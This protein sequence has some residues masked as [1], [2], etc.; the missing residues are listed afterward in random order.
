VKSINIWTH[1]LAGAFFL[2]QGWTE[3]D[4]MSQVLPPMGRCRPLLVVLIQ[5]SES[6]QESQKIVL[7]YSISM[8]ISFLGSAIF[9]WFNPCSKKIH[10][11]LR[12]VDFTG[13]S[14]HIIGSQIALMY[15]TFFCYPNIQVPPFTHPL[16]LIHSPCC[17]APMWRHSCFSPFSEW[18]FRSLI[19][20][21]L[22]D[23][24][25]RPFI[26]WLNN[27]T[28]DRR[29]RISVFV[30]MSSYPV[31]MYIHTFIIGLDDSVNELYKGM[32][33]TYFWYLIGLYFYGSR[34]PES[35]WPGR[36]D[37]WVLNSSCR[38]WNSDTRSVCITSGVA[39][40]SF[41]CCIHVVQF[42]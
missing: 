31:L 11:R 33:L 30:L 19:C 4:R 9:H 38:W 36:F 15:F 21:T 10:W 20:S 39:L 27:H 18:C 16:L 1:L 34:W 12:V 28:N 35:K 32:A 42:V 40:C 17:S 25:A 22:Q 37:I 13:I 7:I 26:G 5:S 14:F 3:V 24:G 41:H 23:S 29:L 2:L 8:T 6:V